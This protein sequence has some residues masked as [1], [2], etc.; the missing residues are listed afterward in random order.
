[1]GE[2]RGLVAWCIIFLHRS[3]APAGLNGI[4]HGTVS[5]LFLVDGLAKGQF[6]RFNHVLHRIQIHQN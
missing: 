3:V 1:M 5:S 6:P 4:I 2:S